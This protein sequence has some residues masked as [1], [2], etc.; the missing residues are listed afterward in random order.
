MRLH[1]S[2]DK[3]ANGEASIAGAIVLKDLTYAQVEAGS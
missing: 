3:L 1:S 2:P